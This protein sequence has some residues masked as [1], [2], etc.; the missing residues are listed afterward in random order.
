MPEDNDDLDGCDLDFTANTDDETESLLIPKG[1]ELKSW[2]EK[3]EK[4]KSDGA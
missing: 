4:E 3:Q 1:K 2:T